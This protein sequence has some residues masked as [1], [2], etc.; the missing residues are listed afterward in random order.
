M[1]GIEVGLIH[2][3]VFA[4]PHPLEVAEWLP[5]GFTGAEPRL[6]RNRRGKDPGAPITSSE[7]AGLGSPNLFTST[8]AGLHQSHA[9]VFF[10]AQAP[11]RIN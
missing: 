2:R 8:L 4:H 9:A 11:N 6:R 10:R 7:I 5:A 1:G 3:W